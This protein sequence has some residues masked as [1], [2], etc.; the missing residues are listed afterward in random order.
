MTQLRA[1][2][3]D[4]EVSGPE[5]GGVLSEDRVFKTLFER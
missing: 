1:E 3:H 5:K 2:L 4:G